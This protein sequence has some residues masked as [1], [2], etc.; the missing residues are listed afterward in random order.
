MTPKEKAGQLFFKYRNLE[1]KDSFI[2]NYNAKQCALIAVDEVIKYHES[3]YN[4]GFKDVHIA[5]SSP[6]KT[7]N[8]ILNPLLK[9]WEEVKQEIEKL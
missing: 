2:N 4:K 8:D 5:L 9:Y 6:I 3:L 7:Y 1:N